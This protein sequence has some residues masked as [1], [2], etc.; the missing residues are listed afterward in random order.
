MSQR[1]ALMHGPTFEGNAA[2]AL[3][4]LAGYFDAALTAATKARTP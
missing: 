4:A 3:D 1:L 2:A